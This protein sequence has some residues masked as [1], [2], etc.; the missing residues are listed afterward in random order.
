MNRLKET[1]I[2]TQ[3][4]ANNVRIQDLAEVPIKPIRP[5]K[6]LNIALSIIL[7]LVGGTGLAFFRE[8]MDTTLKDPSEIASLLQIPVL[9]SV[10]RLRP[11]GKNIKK[12]VD[13]DRVVEKDP[14]SLASESYR[15]IRTNLLFSI[16]HSNS[17]KSIVVTS[18][19]PREGKT[20]TAV[21]LA[22]MIANSG[23]KVLLVDC[24]TRKPRIHTVFNQDNKIGLSHFLLGKNNFDEIVN[25]SEI[26]N[27][28]FVTSG[29]ISNRPAELIS[30]ANMKLF[31]EKASLQFTK[32]IFDTP[33]IT[34]VTDA[35]VVASVAT[36]VVLV[37]EGSRITK[38]LLSKSKELL[39][40]VDAK[41]LGI[42]LNNISPTRDKYSYPQY[43][44]GKYYNVSQ[45]K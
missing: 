10:S 28:Y 8:Y 43:Y 25:R 6:K 26:S 33:P 31:I 12:K 1:S 32:I 20:L 29:R 24:D 37:A 45:G 40:N 22:T 15:T 13:V 17:P 39:Q 34:L 30:S 7:G 14:Y 18:S 41:I 35:A 16:N 42:I 27:L 36:G 11:D 19:V 2:S 38:E 4:Q 21:N 3:V 5:R 9:G 23:E 44:Y